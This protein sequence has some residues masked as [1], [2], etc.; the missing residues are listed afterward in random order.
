MRNIIT[1]IIL[2]VIIF[3]AGYCTGTFLTSKEQLGSVIIKTDIRRDTVIIEKP[4]PV[5]VKA[6]PKTK[7]EKAHNRPV[8][9]RNSPDYINVQIPDSV[10]SKVK[11][12]TSV[13]ESGTDSVRT[14][15]DSNY[16]AVVRGYLESISVYPK[17]VT[18]YKVREVNKSSKF[19]FGVNVGPGIYWNGNKIQP[20]LGVQVGLNYNF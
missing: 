15:A 5:E 8:S 11:L 12:D 6:V 18:V 20:G 4:V 10:A 7:T 16:R 3:M 19:S 1:G 17:T 2:S 13:C 14:Y 9:Q